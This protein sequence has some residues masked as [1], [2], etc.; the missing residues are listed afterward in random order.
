MLTKTLKTV[1]EVPGQANTPSRL[2]APDSLR[3][4]G[5]IQRLAALTCRGI[6]WDETY[7]LITCLF[8]FRPLLCL[9]PE[10]KWTPSCCHGLR[11]IY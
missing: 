4:K 11:L 7:C 8:S 1:A 10:G 6:R 9:V 3:P 5:H 2:S